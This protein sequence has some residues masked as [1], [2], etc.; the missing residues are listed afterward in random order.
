MW[1][2]YNQQ[3]AP[4]LNGS[5]AGVTSPTTYALNLGKARLNSDKRAAVDGDPVNP[6]HYK[7]GTTEV[8][9]FIREQLGDEGFVAYCRGNALKYLSRAG[10]KSGAPKVDDLGKSRWYS[11]MAAHTL[12]PDTYSDPRT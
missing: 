12:D 7:R 8:I 4:P 2:H 10:S 11:Q 6:A 5:L 3:Y 1:E 9:D